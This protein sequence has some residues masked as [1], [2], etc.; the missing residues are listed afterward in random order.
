MKEWF[1]R[2]QQKMEGMT[3]KEKRAYI[4]QYYWHY[5][6]IG[7]IILG[8]VILL[9]YH[10]TVGNKKPIF[11]CVV[12][13]QE[14]DLNRDSKVSADF[15][16]YL[17]VKA[18][19]V[20]FDS[21]YLVSYDDVQSPEANESSYEKFFLNWHVHE[22]DAMIIPES[23]YEYCQRQGGE[24]SETVELSDQAV[25]DKLGLQKPEDEKLLLCIPSDTKHQEE[26][27]KFIEYVM[28][29]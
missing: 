25:L 20:V 10:L 17:S 8:L 9:I 18:D 16:D 4:C 26:G 27:D 28:N 6:L 23:F 7:G 19:R 5:F 24:F 12:V 21:D 22:L 2:I 15:A 1:S 29:S 14:I 11:Q 3:P 13:N